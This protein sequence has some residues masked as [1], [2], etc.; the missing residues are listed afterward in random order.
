MMNIEMKNIST[1]YISATNSRKPGVKFIRS[2]NGG[3]VVVE[4]Q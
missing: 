2:W 1:Q 3:R 4:R